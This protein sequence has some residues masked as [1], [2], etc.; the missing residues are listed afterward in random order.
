[1]WHWYMT[2]YKEWKKI[3][4]S[5]K[6]DWISYWINIIILIFF[7]NNEIQTIIKIYNA[8]DEEQRYMKKF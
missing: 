7:E 2:N 3:G 1:M 5:F 4:K 8:L 6:V